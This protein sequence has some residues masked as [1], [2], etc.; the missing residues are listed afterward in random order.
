MSATSHPIS[1]FRDP[2]VHDLKSWPEHFA[3]VQSGIKNFEVRN[4]DRDYRVF[5]VLVLHEYDPDRQA[6]INDHTI[7]RLITYIGQLDDPRH[8]SVG[9]VVMALSPISSPFTHCYRSANHAYPVV[10]QRSKLK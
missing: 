6:Y 2:V 7:T 9:R 3:A 8:G 5:D 4:N 10:S 1:R